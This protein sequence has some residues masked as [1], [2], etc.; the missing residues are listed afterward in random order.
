LTTARVNCKK[1]GNK[2]I[3]FNLL[4]YMVKPIVLT[5]EWV[6]CNFPQTLYA[7]GCGH[8]SLDVYNDSDIKW[9]ELALSTLCIPFKVNEYVDEDST[10]IDFEFFIEDLK[11]NCPALYKEL[12][13]MD[14]K[15]KIYK[16]LN[17]N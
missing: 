17:I 13:E 12:K 1:D 9:V 6:L 3:L 15:N 16:G 8:V 2:I 11:E 5:P 10:F 4:S 7:D 14:A